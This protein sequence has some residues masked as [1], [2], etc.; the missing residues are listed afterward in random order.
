MDPLNE[1]LEAAR[2]FQENHKMLGDRQLIVTFK[3]GG[4][5]AE[6]HV[7]DSSHRDY[8]TQRTIQMVLFLLASTKEN[9]KWRLDLSPKIIGNAMTGLS[10][11]DDFEE[12]HNRHSGR[13]HSPAPPH[14]LKKEKLEFATPMRVADIVAQPNGTVLMYI[15]SS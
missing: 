10:P 7:Y 2:L 4:R 6:E 8:S 15:E 3:K 1:K 11:W 13:S 14:V 9:G 5:I 12:I